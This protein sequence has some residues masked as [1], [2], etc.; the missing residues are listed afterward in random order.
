MDLTLT[1]DE[2]TLGDSLPH[3]LSISVWVILSLGVPHSLS[4]SFAISISLSQSLFVTLSL[5]LSLRQSLLSL[6]LPDE[7]TL[8]DFHLL[9]SL[10]IVSLYDCLTLTYIH[11][12]SQSLS[13]SFSLSLSLLPQYLTL[14]F[15]LFL[16]L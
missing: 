14:S 16:S 6:S 2:L 4:Q 11:T 3:S 15:S 9:L 7:L 10:E 12:N 8:G 13:P 5:S 1:A